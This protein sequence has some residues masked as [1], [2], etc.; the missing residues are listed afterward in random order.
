MTGEPAM[1]AIAEWSITNLWDEPIKIVRAFEKRSK[2]ESR[3]LVEDPENRCWGRIPILAGEQTELNVDFFVCPIPSGVKEGADYKCT[4]LL[5][6]HL[7]NRYRERVT[8]RGRPKRKEE[9]PDAGEPVHSIADPV[10]KH[11]VSVLKDELTRYRDCGRPVG[12]LGSVQ[13]THQ[14]RVSRGVG[15]DSRTPN[16]PT[17]Q[18]IAEDAQPMSVSSDNAA[19]LLKYLEKLDDEER[20]RF[21]EAL[22][23]RLS[24]ASEYAPIGYFVLLVLFRAGELQRALDTAKEHLQ[25]DDAFGFSDFL[26]LLDGMLRFE[27]PSFSDDDLDDIEAFVKDIEEHAFRIEERV[28]AVRAYR[29]RRDASDGPAD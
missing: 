1:Q 15:T 25:K 10:E 28:A 11:V 18:S 4:I 27:H 7:G 16:V 20:A 17:V 19:G 6:D 8:L 13:T 22:S 2:T 3:P 26:R 29:V 14:G 21:V 12:G 23:R 9:K 24:R 5:I